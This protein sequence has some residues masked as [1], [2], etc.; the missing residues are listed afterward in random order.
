MC[1]QYAGRKMYHIY[2]EKLPLATQLCSHRKRN[3]CSLIW[4]RFTV[5]QVRNGIN[6]KDKENVHP[7]SN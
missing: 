7:K 5:L 1:D 4:A 6:L 3:A 2:N